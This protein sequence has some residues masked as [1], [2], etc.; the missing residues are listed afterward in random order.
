MTA[1]RPL[2]VDWSA[3][4]ARPVAPVHRRHARRRRRRCAHPPR[5]VGGAR[6]AR[7]PAGRGD[8]AAALWRCAPRRGVSCISAS[9][10]PSARWRRPRSAATWTTRSAS[11][12]ARGGLPRRTRSRS[13]TG[14]WPM[15]FPGI[16]AARAG[17]GRP[18]PARARLVAAARPACRAWRDSLA[19]IFADAGRSPADG[20]ARPGLSIYA[21]VASSH[22]RSLAHPGCHVVAQ[23]RRRSPRYTDAACPWAYNFE[24][25]L[26]ALEARYGD[27][28]DVPY[29][30]DRPDGDVRAVVA[31]GS[32]PE[33]ARSP[34]RF[35]AR[36]MPI[37]HRPAQRVRSAPHAPAASSRPPSARGAAGRGPAA[38]AAL[39]LV[40][41]RPPDGY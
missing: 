3:H 15:S 26:R 6:L 33:G 13:S 11:T 2:F 4:C 35:R 30:D 32:T 21:H 25:A 17:R 38:G 34:A 36:G 39:R 40:H 12:T 28:L 20:A 16:W 1:D 41:D 7:Q 24:P 9:S 14:S 37:S 10:A 8:R 27:Q 29:G 22:W 18:R 23:H 5:R 31:R 19:T